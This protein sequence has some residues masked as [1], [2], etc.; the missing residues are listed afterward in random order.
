MNDNID[1]IK[2]F[3]KAQGVVVAGVICFGLAIVGGLSHTAAYVYA[4]QKSELFQML[5]QPELLD[6][7]MEPATDFR[8]GD[9][10]NLRYFMHYEPVDCYGMYV[11]R[12]SGPVI[13]Q[14]PEMR[15]G[16]SQVSAPTDM[17]IAFH[18]ELPAHLP[19]GEY[20]VSLMTFPTCEGLNL[21]PRN[22][23]LGLNMTILPKS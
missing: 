5:D 22:Y 13:F 17:E 4:S 10:F 16:D 9:G 2:G 21:K 12:V 20:K 19:A 15:T 6:Q 7:E 14:F 11:T 1:K 18:F 8:A 23:D 3:L